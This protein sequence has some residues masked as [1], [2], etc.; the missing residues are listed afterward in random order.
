[1]GF[2]FPNLPYLVDGDLKLTQTNAILRYL[3]AKYNLLGENTKVQA[4]S[5]MMLEEAMDMRNALVRTVYNPG[6]ENLVDEYFNQVN[7][8]F[9]R[10]EAFLGSKDWFAGG[11]QPTICDFHVYELLDQHTL[12]RPG[13]LK[14][15]P[16]LCNFLE[17]FATLPKIK[18]YLES[19][20]CI[21]RPCNNK[22]AAWK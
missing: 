6:Y 9:K 14:D 22:H 12:M 18:A 8:K 5:D 19:D 13:C 20:K 16:K 15:Y 7:I 17:R 1:L 2:D 10:Y 3:G 4:H 11:E 21:K